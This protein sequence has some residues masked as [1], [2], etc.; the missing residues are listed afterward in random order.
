MF[1]VYLLYGGYYMKKHNEFLMLFEECV[2][3]YYK[4]VYLYT[5]YIPKC[6]FEKLKR[7]NKIKNENIRKISIFPS[8]GIKYK[9]D[10]KVFNFVYNNKCFEYFK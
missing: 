2:K 3:V 6:A 7:P 4:Y 5:F 9:Y 1:I 8:I 10:T